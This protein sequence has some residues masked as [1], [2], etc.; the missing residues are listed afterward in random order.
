[1][2]WTITSYTLTGAITIGITTGANALLSG[3]AVFLELDDT[4]AG[5]QNFRISNLNKT[6][7]V[8]WYNGTTWVTLGQFTDPSQ[9]LAYFQ[10][11]GTSLELTNLPA[12]PQNVYQ[13]IVGVEAN[14]RFQ[15]D[16]NGKIDW[17]PGAATPVDTTLQRTAAAVLQVTGN[18]RGTA[19]PS[20]IADLT[21]KDYVDN[22]LA[23][24]LALAGGT[25]SGLLVLSA[26]PAVNL[27]AATKQYVDTGVATALP[28]AGGTLTG[29][30]LLAAD[31]TTALQA[32]TK[33]YVDNNIASAVDTKTQLL[34]GAASQTPDLNLGF[35]VLIQVNQNVTINV[36]LHPITGHIMHIVFTHDGTAN[37]YT[38]TWNDVFLMAGDAY[39]NTNTAGAVDT[40]SFVYDGTSWNEIAR[41]LNL[42]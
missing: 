20:N 39:A 42:S 14:P 32:A 17:G 23:L 5:G 21:R 25:M 28:K 35:V 26:D 36:P 38:I 10:L 4:N 24:K 40:V 27:G 6:F 41:A 2:S 31:P 12:G 22:G 1:M 37:A 13:Q 19:V 30:L 11:I 34:T 3:N 18:I 33:Q 9:A 29:P 8:S 15:W 16:T 7:F